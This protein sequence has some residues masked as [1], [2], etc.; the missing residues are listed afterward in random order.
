VAIE[1][2]G[3]QTAGRTNPSS[4]LSVNYALSGGLAAVPAA[5]DFVV[6]TAVTGSAAGNP[7]MAVTTPATW[8]AI[9]QLNQS[10]VTADTSLDVSHKFMPGTPDTAVTIP[11][12]GNNAFGQAYAIQVFRGVDTSNPLDVAAVSAGGTGTGRPNPASIS[13]ATAGAWTVICGGGAAGTG[14][15]YTAPAN[16]ATDFLTASGADTTDAMVGCGYNPSPGSPEDPAVYTG[17]TTGAND[18]WACYTIALRP[19]ATIG[20]LAGTAT[21]TITPAGTMEGAGALAGSCTMSFAPS[22]AAIGSGDMA[23]FSALTFAPSGALELPSTELA[24]TSVISFAPTASFVG[25]GILAGSAIAVFAPTAT[26][27]GTGAMSGSSVAAFVPTAAVTGPGVLAGSSLINFTDNST[28]LAAGALAGVSTAAFSGA[29][30]I[31][32]AAVLGG[33]SIVGFALFAELPAAG[34]LAGESSMSLSP[35]GELDQPSGSMSGASMMMFANSAALVA[36]G[37]L[38]GFASLSFTPQGVL[39]ADGALAGASVMALI[40]G[41]VLAEEVGLIPRDPTVPMAAA[42]L[43]PAPDASIRPLARGTIKAS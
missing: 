28:L 19:A 15:N 37:D 17:G 38:S 20:D 34:A 41:G 14:A 3:G 10:A 11:G 25:D 2:V 24:G 4:A 6:V 1:Y 22:A 31:S 40:A 33:A 30:E 42:I 35:G 36:N 27:A 43:M 18:S 16:Y 39:L 23:G 13:P 7:A 8:N 32:G 5:G 21:S 26:M 12:T 29:A 9:G